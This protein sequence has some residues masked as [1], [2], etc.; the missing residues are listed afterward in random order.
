MEQKKG[1]PQL[2]QLPPFKPSL[3]Q[4]LPLADLGRKKNPWR[5]EIQGEENSCIRQNQILAMIHSQEVA[6]T[7]SDF[8]L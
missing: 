3:S 7:Y 6:P 5:P 4:I 2:P 1:G 8:G